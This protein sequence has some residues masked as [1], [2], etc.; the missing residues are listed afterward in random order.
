MPGVNAPF[1]VCAPECPAT[2]LL[3]LPQS[4]SQEGIDFQI[5]VRKVNSQPEIDQ[6]TPQERPAVFKEFCRAAMRDVDLPEHLEEPLIG[7]AERYAQGLCSYSEPL[8]SVGVVHFREA[9]EVKVKGG[10]L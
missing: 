6:R 3:D 2:G 4:R 1:V 5:A 7:C 9:D 8:Q 10:L